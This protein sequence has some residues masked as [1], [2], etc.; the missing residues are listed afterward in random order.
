MTPGD[1]AALGL[2]VDSITQ[3]ALG[4]AVSYACW[5]KPLGRKAL[6]LGFALGTLPDLDIVAYPLLDE[7]QQLYWHRGESHSIWFMILGS[8]LTAWL[9]R[10]VPWTKELTW[11][12]AYWGTFAIHVS[13]VAID[14]FTVYG[15]QLL[16]PF[17]RHGFGTNNFFII[18]PLFTVPILLGILLALVWPSEKVRRVANLTGLALAT[19][20][21][22]WSFVSQAVA[23]RAFAQALE[24]QGIEAQ[25]TLTT[26]SAFN[27]VLWRH[28]VETDDGFL[29]GYWSW[30][31]D[32]DA[33][34]EF[35]LI[36]QNSET[37]TPVLESR[38]FQVVE[39]FSQG[40]WAVI[41]VED[42][43]AI[44]VDLR[45]GEIPTAPG[46]SVQELGWPFAWEF[47]LN[48]GAEAPLRQIQRTIDDFD[49]TFDLLWRRIGGDSESF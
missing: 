1:I 47:D 38:S 27:T 18:D 15:T 26:A 4:T 31:D 48:A 25:R 46:Q 2:H 45:F 8:W 6:P 24:A 39:W 34:I 33:S 28:L 42:N 16:A 17:S 19:I 36:P 44:M 23:N 41:E 43:R 12:Q 11:R 14:V 35:R 7:V 21:T 5:S 9:L 40:W 32:D 30:F 22:A 3:A 20:Y 10:K 29:I 49:A 13:H 37:M